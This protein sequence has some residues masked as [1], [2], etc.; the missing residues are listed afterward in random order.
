MRKEIRLLSKTYATVEIQR[1]LKLKGV[2]LPYSRIQYWAEHEES[3]QRSKEGWKAY[4]ARLKENP[5][6]M[7]RYQDRIKNR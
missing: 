4:R 3:K 6:L 5:D 7:K 2:E 1:L